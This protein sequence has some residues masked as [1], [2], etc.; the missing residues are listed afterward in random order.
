MRQKILTS[1]LIIFLPLVLMAQTVSLTF[2]GRG[3]ADQH[4]QLDRI[5]ITN[6]TKGWSETLYWPDTVLT[7]QN[8]TGIAEM[9]N[10]A[11]LQLFQN[12]PNPFE[13]ATD[14]NLTVADAGT[15]TLEIS[16]VTG[17]CVETLYA[18][19]LQVG[20]HQFRV[21]LS[22]TGL[23]VMTAKQ[24]GNVSSVKMA[25][26]GIGEANRIEYMGLIEIAALHNST[27][28]SRGGTSNPFTFGD[29]MEYVGYAI[30]DGNEYES[31][32]I[33][34]EQGTSQTFVLQFSVTPPQFNCGT[35][36]LTDIEGNSYSTVQIGNQCWMAE[37]LR[38]TRYADNTVIEQGS[39]GFYNTPFWFYADGDATTK[40]TY[41]LLYNWAA[42]MRG[43][44]F[45]PNPTD[46]LQGICPLGWHMPS[47]EEWIQLADYVS[48]QSTY[49][50]GNAP[51]NISKA[52][53][54]TTGWN[55]DNHNCAV[56]NNPEANNATGFGAMPAGTY[57]V[58]TTINFHASAALWT[59]TEYDDENA[60][61]RY[62]T[63]E[64][65]TIHIDYYP[66]VIGKSVR[67]IRD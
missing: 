13:G 42:A 36:M 6:L 40:P 49:V 66:K 19:S 61:A 25:C 30:I 23:Y 64:A 44:T 33:T 38:T 3:S 28:K 2:S 24:N 55:S 29:R 48:S 4:I 56:G 26:N 57:S 7:M 35:S 15:V 20:N 37:N 8:G 27:Q 58:N 22:Q 47:H 39:S 45:A 62:I 59:A 43:G 31:Q 60:Y 50:C 21:T 32:R 51:A 10:Q 16:D 5:T 11:S 34:Q 65:A 54:S 12:N 18:T 41:G 67:C 46:G 52:L 17:R 1:I 9:E 53:A 14:V 63:Q